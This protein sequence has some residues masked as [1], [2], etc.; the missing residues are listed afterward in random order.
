MA[1]RGRCHRLRVTGIDRQRLVEAR[2]GLP[3]AGDGKLGQ[4]RIA[5]QQKIV[6]VELS[7]TIMPDGIQQIVATDDAIA[8]VNQELQHI[9]D[10]EFDC[11]QL[12]SPAQLAPGNIKR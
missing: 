11:N 2:Q 5:T 3:H 6:G 1:I 4:Q 12:G 10:L 7:R 8:C 9:E